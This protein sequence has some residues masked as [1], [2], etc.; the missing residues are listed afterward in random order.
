MD[1]GV[2][3][4]K[5]LFSQ[6]ANYQ[7][8][9][10]SHPNFCF[11]SPVCMKYYVRIEW[12]LINIVRDIYGRLVLGQYFQFGGQGPG[13]QQPRDPSNSLLF[14]QTKVVDKPLQGGGILPKPTDFPRRILSE[15]GM[16]HDEIIAL[17]GN[18][19][20]KRSAKDQKDTFRDVLR[21]AADKTLGLHGLLE[22]AGEEESLLHKTTRKPEV[23]ALPEILTTYSML[24][25]K[26][27]KDVLD[28]SAGPWHGNL[29]P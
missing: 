8:Q 24:K 13:L 7:A 9:S 14:E 26:E 16:S 20:E 2:S 21:V 28:A 17:E 12:D 6:Y 27:E 25:K 19:N 5:L 15:I 23:A 22:R 1:G 29:F 3:D 10:H 11:P 4:S 18:L